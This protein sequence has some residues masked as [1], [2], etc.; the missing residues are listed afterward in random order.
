MSQLPNTHLFTK[1][2]TKKEALFHNVTGNNEVSFVKYTIIK[3]S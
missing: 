1:T 3:R 2:S